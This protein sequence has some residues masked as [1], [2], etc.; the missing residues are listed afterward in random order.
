MAD[1]AGPSTA[2]PESEPR[3]DTTT[4]GTK[5]GRERNTGLSSATVKG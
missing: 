2:P 3:L 1:R 4:G 5:I